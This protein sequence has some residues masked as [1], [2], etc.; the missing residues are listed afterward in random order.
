MNGETYASL[1]EAYAD[2]IWPDRPPYFSVDEDW[3]KTC[4]TPLLILPG[5]D[6]FHP[7]SIAEQICRDAR[8][9]HCLDVDCRSEEKLSGT[10]EAVRSF[11]KEHTP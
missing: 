6:A 1:I 9:A 2:A 3:V 8:N 4:E 10:I 11:L 5:S 7:T